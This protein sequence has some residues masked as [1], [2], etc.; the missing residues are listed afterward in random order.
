MIIGK[1][2]CY[3]ATTI[4]EITNRIGQ[5]IQEKIIAWYSLEIPIRAGIKDFQGLPGAIVSLEAEGLTYRLSEIKTKLNSRIKIKKPSGG[6]IVT[7]DEFD[8]ILLRKYKMR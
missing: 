6:K 7:Q 3:K 5:K 2:T 4:K 1:Y 8:K